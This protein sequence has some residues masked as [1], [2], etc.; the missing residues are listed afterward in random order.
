[1]F[2]FDFHTVDQE[3]LASSSATVRPLR[4]GNADEHPRT[5]VILSQRGGP[6]Q[7][8]LCLFPKKYDGEHAFGL[9]QMS[10]M[11]FVRSLRR[12]IHT[13]RPGSHT[14]ELTCTATTVQPREA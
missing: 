5:S 14:W 7:Q 9:G 2:L 8:K 1:M 6:Q 3:K 13:A 12:R 11:F 10:G 4:T